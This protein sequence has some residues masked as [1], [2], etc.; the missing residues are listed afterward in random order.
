MKEKYFVRVGK[1]KVKERAEGKGEKKV[2][3][4]MKVKMKDGERMKEEG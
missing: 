4:G 3:D 2:K 1:E